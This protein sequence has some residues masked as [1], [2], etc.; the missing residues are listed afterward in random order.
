[1]SVQGKINDLYDNT[2]QIAYRYCEGDTQKAE[3]FMD[4][5]V[6][7]FYYRMAHKKMFYDWQEQSVKNVKE[8]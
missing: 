7:Q 2:I 5:T 1:M 4:A 3:H 6:Y 8:K